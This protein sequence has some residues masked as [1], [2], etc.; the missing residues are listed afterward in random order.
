MCVRL[1]TGFT[2]FKPQRIRNAI[3]ATVPGGAVSFNRIGFHHFAI[4]LGWAR[5]KGDDSE[6][7]PLLCHLS[8]DATSHPTSVRLEDFRDIVQNS[9]I[10][11]YR[12]Y[13]SASRRSQVICGEKVSHQTN[14]TLA[15]PLLR[16]PRLIVGSSM[17]GAAALSESFSCAGKLEDS[18]S[19]GVLNP[20]MDLI[21]ITLSNRGLNLTSIKLNASCTRDFEG[22]SRFCKQTLYSC[23]TCAGAAVCKTCQK[24]CHK[25][26]QLTAGKVQDGQCHCTHSKRKEATQLHPKMISEIKS[27]REI[28]MVL[29]DS[30]RITVG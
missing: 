21:E 15:V 13:C 17:V 10:R 14:L 26:C 25:D 2:D 16:L 1:K 8:G 6:P 4:F 20:D 9:I 11:V 5:P 27:Q 18:R 28:E 3:R 7:I 24:F 30:F 29:N 22:C 23:N 19:L 12:C